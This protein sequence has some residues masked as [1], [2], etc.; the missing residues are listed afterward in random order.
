MQAST[1]TF[2]QG[3]AAAGI[4]ARMPNMFGAKE[5]GIIAMSGVENHALC[6][7]WDQIMMSNSKG[8][9][10]MP[11]K[12]ASM[13][14]QETH[15]YAHAAGS[16]QQGFIFAAFRDHLEAVVAAKC[17]DSMQQVREGSTSEQ[18]HAGGRLPTQQKTASS[19]VDPVTRGASLQTISRNLVVKS[20]LAGPQGTHTQPLGSIDHLVMRGNLLVSE[21]GNVIARGAE[22]LGGVAL[23]GAVK[24]EEGRTPQ[25][26]LMSIHAL[27]CS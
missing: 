1:H 23:M 4:E 21:S 8:F 5:R 9:V 13:V 6:N 2:S 3:P 10:N 25:K 20:N 22:R 19:G 24:N 12:S 18:F 27:V 11:A 7:S 15:T 26:D 16:E 14:A 17:L